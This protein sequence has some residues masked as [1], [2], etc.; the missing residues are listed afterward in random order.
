[1]RTM[2]DEGRAIFGHVRVT[3]VYVR[4][5]ERVALAIALPHELARRNAHRSLRRD[6]N[7]L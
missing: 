2:R 5:E 3:C 7:A 6:R 1:M 4:Y